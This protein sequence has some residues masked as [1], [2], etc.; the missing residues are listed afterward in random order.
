MADVFR[1]SDVYV[2]F[3]DLLKEILSKYAC[4]NPM[5]GNAYSQ[6]MK[7]G[8][9]VELNESGMEFIRGGIVALMA[10]WEN[11]VHDLFDEAFDTLIII[12]SGPEG[13]LERLEKQW[14]ACSG[15][16]KKAMKDEEEAY[17]L[18][19]KTDQGPDKLWMELLNT[20]RRKILDQRTLQPIF[21]YMAARKDNAMT[22]DGLFMQLFE[23]KREKISRM[24]VEVAKSNYFLLYPADGDLKV[25]LDPE[26]AHNSAVKALRNISR[27]YYG[28]RCIFVHG[29]KEKTLQEALLDFPEDEDGFPLPVQED[30]DVKARK[31]TKLFKRVQ[32]MGRNVHVSYLT[33]LNVANFIRFAAIYLMQAVAKWIY[34]L[35][36][37]GPRRAPVW[38]YSFETRSVTPPPT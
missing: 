12:C 29:K 34:D 10:A 33:F 18:M 35:Q 17:K 26:A 19:K 1:K 14:S 28:L 4:L 16:I 38:G 7:E 15:I 24:L 30:R 2:A 22:I 5:K 13:S 21:N 11:Y 23:H 36:P 3:V 31:Y 27:L 9:D 20:H 32:G 37:Q 6:L 8:S 25:T